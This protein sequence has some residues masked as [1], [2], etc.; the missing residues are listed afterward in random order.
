DHEWI[1]A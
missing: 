1:Q